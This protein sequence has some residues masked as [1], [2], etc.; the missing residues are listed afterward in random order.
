MAGKTQA[1][2]T[3]N[4]A[5]FREI[6]EDHQQLQSMLDKLRKMVATP[7]ALANHLKEF[8]ERMSDLRDQLAFHFT[9]EE[10]YGYFEDAIERAPRF[11]EPAGRLRAQHGDLYMMAER[12]AEAAASWCNNPPD[13]EQAAEC[14]VEQFVSFDTVFKTHEAAELKLILDAIHVDVGGGG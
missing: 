10:A 5:F 14:L 2:F 3:V 4:A 1:K 13:S 9:L 6:K 12:I 8:S 7:P 11:H